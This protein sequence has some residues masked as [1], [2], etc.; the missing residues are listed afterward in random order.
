MLAAAL[1]SV[2]LAVGMVDAILE[3]VSDLH[4]VVYQFGLLECLEERAVHNHEVALLRRKDIEDFTVVL[5]GC[6]VCLSR[7]LA[8]HDFAL[9]AL[10]NLCYFHNRNYLFE[11]I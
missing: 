3:E 11:T 5:L 1:S 2:A 7:S 9:D 4:V 6:V 10:D 8:V